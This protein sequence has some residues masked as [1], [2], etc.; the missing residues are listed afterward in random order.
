MESAIASPNPRNPSLK[1][2]RP[3]SSFANPTPLSNPHLRTA[4]AYNKPAMKVSPAPVGSTAAGGDP[5]CCTT[6]IDVEADVEVEADADVEAEA[7]VRGG[8]QP[9]TS[10]STGSS[11]GRFCNAAAPEEPQVQSSVAEG[12]VWGIWARRK[13]TGVSGLCVSA[14]E[15][16][17]ACAVLGR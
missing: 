13:E 10:T 5:A 2:F 14:G 1:T 11:P 6:D 3:A 8:R 17:W 9:D 15:G 7:E 4:N 16:A 12:R